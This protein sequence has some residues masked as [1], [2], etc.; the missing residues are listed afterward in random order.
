MSEDYQRIEVITGPARRHWSTE[1]KLRIIEEG[2]APGETVSSVARRN[3]VAP[4]LLY[5]WR[6]PMSEG[7]VTAVGSDEP[8]V[9]MSEVRKLEERVRDLERRHLYGEPM[10]SD[11]LELVESREIQ[12]GFGYCLWRHWNN[13]RERWP[14]R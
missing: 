9:G 2:C 14:T 10:P 4:N 12:Q 3:G 6:R 1:H 7:G 5:R 8:V 11:R 13:K